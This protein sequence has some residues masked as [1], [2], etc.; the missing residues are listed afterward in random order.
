ML[1]WVAPQPSSEGVTLGKLSEERDLF[2][3]GVLEDRKGTLEGG[4]LGMY[5]MCH[6]HTCNCP[7][8]K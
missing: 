6:M 1:C 2:V 5:T 8:D 4:E 3:E 7:K